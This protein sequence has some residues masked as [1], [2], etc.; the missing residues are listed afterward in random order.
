[1]KHVVSLIALASFGALG[2]GS[3]AARAPLAANA[4]VLALGNDA[5]NNPCEARRVFGDPQARSRSDRVFDLVCGREDSAQ[6]VVGRLVL[7]RD[8]SGALFETWRA[9]M[10]CLQPEAAPWAPAA[11]AELLLA[12]RCLGGTADEFGAQA[13]E[14]AQVLLAARRS[15]ALIAG[16]ATLAAA[17]PLERGLRL[18]LGE[19]VAIDALAMGPS[20]ELASSMRVLLGA[21]P[22][23]GGVLDFNTLRRAAY[24]S[25]AL[26]QFAAAE[27]QFA[28]AIRQH[29]ELWPLDRAGRADLVSELALNLSNQRR[30]REAE[31][32]LSEARALAEGA[33]ERFVMAKVA[34]YRA[35]HF[36]N[37][38]NLLHASTA[39]TEARAALE[40]WRTEANTASTPLNDDLA[41]VEIR[42]V[43]LEAQLERAE[44]VIARTESPA[45]A[46]AAWERVRQRLEALPPRYATGPLV[47][48]RQDRA[49]A[50]LQRGDAAQAAP[51]LEAALVSLRAN[52]RDTRL[53]A[54]L[55]MDLGEAQ[56]ALGSVAAAR[57]SHQQAFQIFRA[58]NEN[59]GST[60]ARAMAYLG[61]LAQAL[62]SSPGD[63]DLQEEIFQAFETVSNPAIA[64]SAAA[65]AARLHADPALAREVR[66]LQDED[67]LIRRKRAELLQAI[68]ETAQVLEKE[69][70][71]AVQRREALAQAVVR[72]FPR[73][74][75]VLLEPPQLKELQRQLDPAEVLVRIVLGEDRGLGLLVERGSF[76]VFS[77]AAGEA[78]VARRVSAIRE[79]IQSGAFASEDAAGLF[80]LLFG[81]VRGRLLSEQDGAERR[82]LFDVQGSLASMPLGVLLTD[83]P[84]EQGVQP[85]LMRKASIAYAPGARALVSAREANRSR[86]REGA[87]QRPLAAFGAFASVQD[88]PTLL[89][90]AKSIASMRGLDSSCEIVLARALASYAPLRETE[91][92]V[93]RAAS[94]LK[95]SPEDVVTGA[96]FSDAEFEPGAS[97][98]ERARILHFAT[99]GVFRSDFNHWGTSEASCLPDAALLLSVGDGQDPF[100]DLSDILQLQLDADLV[101]LSACDTGNPEAIDP[102]QTGFSTGGDALSGLA[103]AFTYAGARSV[104]IS[105]WRLPDEATAAL[106]SRFF[107]NLNGGLAPPEA[108]SAAQRQAAEEAQSVRDWG[109]FEIIG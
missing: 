68:P 4:N 104:L 48:F 67:R 36:L 32:K 11:P 83:S 69:L 13:G 41:P 22:V 47:A 27:A 16:D 59:R 6:A 86:E 85:F 72:R 51:L 78:D 21:D 37:A 53:E 9:S 95:A 49:Q 56:M 23:G 100:L 52:A 29:Q 60:P 87:E 61:L 81:S 70:E 14:P 3:A 101:L 46:E 10:A 79:S 75:G 66:K 64:K 33:S 43:L 103:R 17:A 1:M 34:V 26:W 65:S 35:V 106:I 89:H 76:S 42:A 71:S 93:Q 99:H 50:L 20:S 91:L 39:L 55:L 2:G 7:V 97:R 109:A 15:D 54:N 105:Q 58:Q 28:A 73:Y 82:L 57:A 24:E 38:Q 90:Y 63:A 25:N 92:E 102:G 18:L 31:Q 40:V 74:S 108:L 30:F 19:Q 84:V 94:I 77:I 12:F 45:R 62:Q 44:A 107:E 5:A 88:G 98:A 80:S 8:A 96:R